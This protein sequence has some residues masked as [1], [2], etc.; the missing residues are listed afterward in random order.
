LADKVWQGIQLRKSWLESILSQVNLQLV[1]RNFKLNNLSFAITGD[2]SQPRPKFI[3]LIES[4]GGKFVN[5]VS[6]NTSYLLTNEID[7][8]SSKFKTAQKL[9]VKIINENDFQKLL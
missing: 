2:L 5:S 4:N 1:T 6:K 7:S 3:E 8:N 9:N